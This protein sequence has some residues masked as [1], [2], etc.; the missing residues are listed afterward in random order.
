MWSGTDWHTRREGDCG[1][2]CHAD[3]YCLMFAGETQVHPTGDGH[4][5]D[6]ALYGRSQEV[7]PQRGKQSPVSF[8]GQP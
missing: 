4:E 6:A 2:V 3:V 8:P 5:G 1:S 7:I